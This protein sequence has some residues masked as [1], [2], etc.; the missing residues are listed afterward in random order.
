MATEVNGEKAGELATVDFCERH[1]SSSAHNFVRDFIAFDR[2]TPVAGRS[3][4][5]YHYAKKFTE[6]FLRHFD[7]ELKR[8]SF[9]G[10]SVAEVNNSGH[11][12][13]AQSWQEVS[14]PRE[15][16]N[17]ET[18]DYADQE[19]SP[20][21]GVSPSRKN[22]KGILR[23]FSLKNIRKSRL[24]K[25]SSDEVDGAVGEQHANPPH[26]HAGHHRKHSKHRD[27]KERM[28]THSLNEDGS[29]NKVEGIVHVL[30]P[31]E[32]SRGRTRWEKTRLVLVR[33][34]GGHLLEFYTPPKSLKPRNGLFCLLIH[35]VRETS[36]LEMPDRENTLVLKGEG[37]VEYVI[38]APDAAEL[39]L[40]LHSIRQC[41]ASAGDSLSSEELAAMRPRLPTA[42][43][44]SIERKENHP[45]SAGH[46]SSSQGSLGNSS[47]DLAP[48]P[49]PRPRSMVQPT[50]LLASH[51]SSTTDMAAGP[52]G[53]TASDQD[54]GGEGSVDCRLKEYPWFHGTLSRADAAQLVLQQGPSGHGVFLVR[55]S[56]TRTG[57]Y[58][59]T[60]N[61]QG[62][63]KHLRMTINSDRRCRVQHLWFETIFDMLEH[64][65]T[66]PI[67]LE[68]GGTSDVT[69]T[70]YMVAMERPATPTSLPRSLAWGTAGRGSQSAPHGAPA[71]DSRDVVVVSGSVRSRTS[72]IENVVREQTSV[73][74]Q[75]GTRAVDN[76]YSF[77]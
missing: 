58:V 32:D 55:K 30:Q 11:R 20:E 5:P 26:Q 6:F 57:E 51:T 21:R 10:D 19:G 22:T 67:P 7:Y 36:A 52:R 64:F 66:H 27:K 73:A 13:V 38:E 44:G 72:S 31:G 48:R 2:N 47:A 60:F 39:R 12:D 35:E 62:R 14:R 9:A 54:G 75:L 16:Q 74:Q 41:M 68:S 1:A 53:D 25:Q 45:L 69:L 18:D 40:W 8:S 29:V 23:R 4:D 34:S 61:F 65:R 3:R 77:V 15:A 50:A 70:D 71:T 43:S 24:F 42:P 46:R 49:A 33:A 59:L 56:E 37:P 63:A 17:G 76:H 28:R